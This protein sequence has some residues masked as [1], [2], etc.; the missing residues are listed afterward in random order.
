MEQLLGSLVRL[1]LT[2]F[3]MLTLVRLSGKRSIGKATPF[4][5]LVALMLGEFFGDLVWG[6]VPVAQG[7]VAVGT[8]MILHMVVA[9]ASYRSIPFDQLVGSKPELLVQDGVIVRENMARQY[10]Q[11]RDL[12][13]MLREWGLEERGEVRVATLEP[14]G[15]L[16]VVR[17]EEA[18]VAEK[19]DLASM[20][21]GRA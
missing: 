4:D 11:D 1:S 15:E 6:V 18:K 16:S 21:E 14:T 7:L 19:R 13:M 12:D 5:F 2:Y 20:G 10:I 3:Y 17:Q 9:Y 8:V